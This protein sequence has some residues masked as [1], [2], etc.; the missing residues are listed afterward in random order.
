M[1]TIPSLTALGWDDNENLMWMH[2]KL[3]D[4]AAVG[5]KQLSHVNKASYELTKVALCNHF[6]H[7]SKKENTSIDFLIG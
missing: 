7:L 5:Y 2:V 4:K 6:E 3:V 1:N